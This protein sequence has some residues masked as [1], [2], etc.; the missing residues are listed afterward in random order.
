MVC[1]VEDRSAKS[2]LAIQV[3]AAV[4]LA[5]SSTSS[6]A[7]TGST[8]NMTGWGGDSMFTSMSV[9]TGARQPVGSV[10]VRITLYVPGSGKVWDGSN[11]S[12]V[13][14]SS[15]STNNHSPA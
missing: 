2:G 7:Q 1:D 10:T 8:G 15:T 5:M 4:P 9:L 11:S 13:E 6:P 12:L 3:S 14:L